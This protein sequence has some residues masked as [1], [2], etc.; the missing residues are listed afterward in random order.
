MGN[1]VREALGPD[2]PRP[3]PSSSGDMT[4]NSSAELAKQSLKSVRWSV[5]SKSVS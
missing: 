5:V 3:T 2:H 4:V 1:P